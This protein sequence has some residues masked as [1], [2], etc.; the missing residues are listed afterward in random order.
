MFND[1]THFPDYSSGISSIYKRK[2]EKKTLY[3][4]G[5]PVKSPKVSQER[6]MFFFRKNPI[7]LQYA[8][9]NL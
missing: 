7:W 5:D 1:N 8:I 6:N 4:D 9:I 2:F 3:L